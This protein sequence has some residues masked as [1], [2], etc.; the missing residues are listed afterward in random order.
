MLLHILSS[1]TKAYSLRQDA[2]ALSDVPQSDAL[3]ITD[4]Q[5]FKARIPPS[6]LV[7]SIPKTEYICSG[8]HIAAYNSRRQFCARNRS[9]CGLTIIIRHPTRFDILISGTAT[10]WHN[11]GRE[12]DT[13]RR[14]LQAVCRGDLIWQ[15]DVERPEINLPAGAQG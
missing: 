3:R 15:R 6:V 9:H 11:L 10:H 2:R 1:V 4:A 13:F 12:V 8:T 5:A 14:R 7:P